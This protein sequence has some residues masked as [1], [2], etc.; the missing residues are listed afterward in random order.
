MSYFITYLFLI[1]S[2]YVIVLRLFLHRMCQAIWSAT[3]S[4]T[5][6]VQ[7]PNSVNR[8]RTFCAVHWVCLVVLYMQIIYPL[9]QFLVTVPLLIHVDIEL[10][11]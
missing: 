3:F 6:R 11:T 5:K 8:G 7:T 2:Q 9:S 10:S 4:D 1:T